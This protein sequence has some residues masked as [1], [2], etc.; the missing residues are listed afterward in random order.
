[1]MNPTR[2]KMKTYQDM[3]NGPVDYEVGELIK[4]LR[5]SHLESGGDPVDFPAFLAKQGITA[6]GP[7][8][9]VDDNAKSIIA[10][11]KD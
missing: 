5:K 2:K 9:K 1:M 10:L 11:L 8:I 6:V 7:F 3:F 4:L